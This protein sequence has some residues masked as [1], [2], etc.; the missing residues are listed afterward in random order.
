MVPLAVSLI[1]RSFAWANS[2]ASEPNVVI[3]SLARTLKVDSEGLSLIRP[4]LRNERSTLYFVGDVGTSVPRWVV[5]QTYPAAAIG[6]VPTLPAAAELRALALLQS[7]QDVGTPV[8][9]PVGV[10]SDIDALAL[11]FV[12]GRLVGTHIAAHPGRRVPGTLQVFEAAG[13]YLRRVH[14]AGSDGEIEVDLAE[15]ASLVL[16]RSTD[17]LSGVGLSLPLPVATALRRTPSR[18]VHVRRALLYGDFVPVNLIA[19]PSNQIV[20]IDP[21]LQE[22]GLPEEDAARFVTFLVSNTRLIPGLVLPSVR[23]TGRELQ[24]AFLT[25]WSGQPTPSTL[26]ELR[27]LDALTL[28]WIR[29]RELT[30]LREAPARARRHVMD[31]FMESL[32]VKVADRLGHRSGL[33]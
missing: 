6:S 31:R 9:R 7:W 12:E 28:R 1:Y 32:M 14:N 27:L 29:R 13:R 26:L 23:R 20:G 15:E 2:P 11:E 25:G 30:R 17:A 5:K 19:T 3:A 18:Q 10:L 24:E 8:A 16:R 21:A 4:P 33:G 22:V